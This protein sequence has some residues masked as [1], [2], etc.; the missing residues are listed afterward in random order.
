M[1]WERTGKRKVAEGRMV[2]QTPLSVLVH[3]GMCADG[4]GGERVELCFCLGWAGLGW[5]VLCCVV[6]YCIVL[7][8]VAAWV[9][10]RRKQ[11]TE[12]TT[13]TTKEYVCARTLTME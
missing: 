6:L 2:K 5:V 10:L 4:G 8:C 9:E 13:T 12:A 1:S 3:R 7:C 11:E